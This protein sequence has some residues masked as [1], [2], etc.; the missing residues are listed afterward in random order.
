M[1]NI[2]LQNLF[3]S[4]PDTTVVFYFY[5]ELQNSEF[6]KT[7]WVSSQILHMIFFQKFRIIQCIFWELW[8]KHSANRICQTLLIQLTSLFYISSCRPPIEANPIGLVQ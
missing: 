2:L 5:L 6:S 4:L 1:T 3:T 7:D 8:T